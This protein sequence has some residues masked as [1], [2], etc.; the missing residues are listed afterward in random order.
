MR[1]RFELIGCEMDFEYQDFAI[2][3][4]PQAELY[5]A[6]LLGLDVEQYYQAICELA[7]SIGG[8]PGAS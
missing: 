1:P 5:G 6:T 8:E 7:D 2:V 4:A 3:E